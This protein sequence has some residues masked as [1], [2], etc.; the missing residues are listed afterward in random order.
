MASQQLERLIAGMGIVY[1]GNRITLVSEELAA[2]FES[3]D[4]LVVVPDDGTILH[5]GAA[6]HELVD[7]AMTAASS[8]FAALGAVGDA[9][10]TDFYDRFAD[11]LAD[12]VTFAPIS[13]ANAADVDAAARAGRSTTRLELSDK[14]RADMIAGLH[15]WRDAPSGRDT[16]VETVQHNGWRVE[17]RRA[18]VGVVGFVFEGRPNVFADATGVLRSGNTVVFRIGSDA[19]GTARAIARHALAPALDGAGIDRGAVTLLDS[20]SRATG[21]ALFSHPSLALAVARGSGQAVAQ[22]G[23]V[24]RQ[25]G[26]PAS[27]HGTGGAWI[28]A[29]VGADA[30]AFGAAVLHSLDRK[31]CNTANVCCIV[32]SRAE[33]LVPVF[34]DALTLAAS[35][36]DTSAKLHVEVSSRRFVPVSWF[37]REVAIRRADGEHR[38]RQAELINDEELG[39]EWEWEHSPEASLVVVDDVDAA[40]RVFNTRSP[41]L[42]ASLISH[43]DREHD[44][45]WATIDAPFVGNGFTRWVD[46]QFALGRPELGLSNWQNGR[47]FGR[48]AVLSGDSVFTIRTRVVQSDPDLHR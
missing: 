43:D 37:E 18:G 11:G 4:R 30:E 21:W 36:R 17:Q 13:T 10:I 20:P 39:T 26:I 40:V 7:A 44:R 9:Q 3:G 35:R 1:G 33:D 48:G 23:A 15:V 24:A 27:L 34:L 45:F 46:G 28:V 38:E 14:M 41:R 12:D 29:G 31:V 6:E 16:L 25:A 47:L 19:L 32:R 42:V 22:L 5:V 2:A 8:A